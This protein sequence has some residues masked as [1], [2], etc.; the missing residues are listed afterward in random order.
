MTSEPGESPLFS[1]VSGHPGA[2]DLAALT[3]VVTAVLAARQR[4]AAARAAV[5]P[6]PSAWRDRASLT[7]APLRP[8]PGAWRRS[9]RPA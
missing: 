2:E 9:G 4:A 7:R 6:A 1:V 3:A 8:G 5:G